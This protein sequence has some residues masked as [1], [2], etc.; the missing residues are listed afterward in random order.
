[1]NKQ[2]FI[3]IALGLAATAWGGWLTYMHHPLMLDAVLL[4]SQ[5]AEQFGKFKAGMH[6]FVRLIPIF[7]LLGGFGLLM[8]KMWGLRLLHTI[9]FIDIFI[10]IFRIGRY[11]YYWFK[12][13]EEIEISALQYF[14]APA[15]LALG[16]LI[17]IEII[18][19]NFSMQLKNRLI[20]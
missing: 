10:N 8:L 11:Y 16:M 4:F 18:V 14:L 17:L 1:M 9:V 7:F 15:M 20:D 13:V 2:S 12:P 6:L 5:T 3:I 19:L